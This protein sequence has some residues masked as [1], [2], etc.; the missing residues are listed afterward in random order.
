M[1]VEKL[2]KH[3]GSGVILDVSDLRRSRQVLAIYQPCC[4]TLGVNSGSYVPGEPLA[5]PAQS[6][7]P[8]LL[9]GVR[10]AFKKSSPCTGVWSNLG[11]TGGFETELLSH[12]AQRNLRGYVPNFCGARLQRPKPTSPH[13]FAEELIVLSVS[14]SVSS[15]AFS[16]TRDR[17]HVPSRKNAVES[18]AS[19][20]ACLRAPS[21]RCQVNALRFRTART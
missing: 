14:V 13:G 4:Y 2:S 5:S 16:F 8:P 9:K 21:L 7:L 19:L 20:L 18:V 15:S 11:P 12:K 1:M 10:S 17:T 3:Y 6:H